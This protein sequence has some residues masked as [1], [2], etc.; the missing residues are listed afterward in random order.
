MS[1]LGAGHSLG[2]VTAA[3][4]EVFQDK[5]R[6]ISLQSPGLT[7]FYQSLARQEAS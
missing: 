2:G 4:K 7:S 3:C 5:L 1:F 6:T